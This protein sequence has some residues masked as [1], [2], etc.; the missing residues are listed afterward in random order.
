MLDNSI[1]QAFKHRHTDRGIDALAYVA[2]CRFARDWSD[3]PT[4]LALTPMAV[5]EHLGKRA[6]RDTEEANRVL[7]ELIQLLTDTNLK[8][9]TVGFSRPSSLV[10]LMKAI[11]SDDVHLTKLIR[12]I[13]GANWQTDLKTSFGVKIPLSVA[14]RA[15][16]NK[17]RLKYLHPWY[18]QFVLSSRIEKYIIEQSRHQPGIVPIGSGPMSRA[19]ADMNDFSKS[20][21][22]QGLGDID[23]LQHCDINS[24]YQQR[25]PYVKLGQT[26]DGN[27]TKVLRFRHS[28][29]ESASIVCG[30]P[31]QKQQI[32]EVVS[33]LA[34]SPFAELEER[35]A[36]VRHAFMEF[37]AA[38][39]ALCE[40]AQNVET[41]T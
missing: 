39:V 22:L 17:L 24:Q 34:K 32:E 15:I 35:G 16:H 12:K 40:T 28:Y 31:D 26:L 9:A 23:M 13:D 21:L 10:S 4:Y 18:V 41:A 1:L 38:L 7:R 5:Y 37:F 36:P 2:F 6:V 8:T 33:M 14:N 25:L 19:M 27:L 20:G 29:Y 3:R 30:H 11:R